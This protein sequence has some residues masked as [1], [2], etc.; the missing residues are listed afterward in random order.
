MVRRRA[1]FGEQWPR[2]RLEP[3]SS[4]PQYDQARWC[5]AR[6]HCALARLASLVLCLVMRF[7]LPETW[8]QATNTVVRPITLED[9]FQMALA[10]NLDVQIERCAPELAR[11]RLR[12]SYGAYDP[13][14]SVRFERQV[15]SFP[16][17]VDPPRRGLDLAYDL[18]ADVLRPSLFGRLPT[19]LTFGLA[20]SAEYLSAATVFPPPTRFIQR[21]N[22]YA[23]MVEL[24]LSQPLL[25]DF[26]TDATRLRIMVNR[27]NLRVA[28]LALRYRIMRTVTQVEIAYHELIAARA[29]V[30]VAEQALA[31][32]QQL[33]DENRR[34]VQA[35]ALPP[36]EA[37]QAQA[38][39]ATAAARLLAAQQAFAAQ[40]IALKLLISDDLRA[41]PEV[42][43]AP[44]EAAPAPPM[45][46]QR[47]QSWEKAMTLRPDLVQARLEVEK[48]DQ[49]LRY[50]RNQLFPNLDVVGVF[51][52]RAV[53]NDLG[54]V[55][56]GIAEVRHP[57]YTI[58]MVLRLPLGNRAAR[59]AY[60]S[61]QAAKEQALARLKRLE[62][63]I[64]AQIDVAGQQ[65]Q[66]AFD[67]HRAAQRGEAAA[68]LALQAE[69]RKLRAGQ[70]T[71]FEMLRFQRNLTDARSVGVRAMADYHRAL[72]EL[73]LSEGA[74]LER[75]HLGVDFK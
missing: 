5:G 28:E 52:A 12:S 46:Y 10:H 2:R 26:W 63:Q 74:T 42:V 8:A 16:E 35:G 11:Y 27:K 69:E 71:F 50:R 64:L 32:A 72:A 45:V 75:H 4:N 55:A 24:T 21:T 7:W 73:A 58:G 61:A 51:G 39:A 30:R 68:Q 59:H 38:Q 22:Q 66:T 49:E 15:A 47:N 44:A 56:G 19:G 62:E 25:K 9:C 14:F 20:A 65:L 17:I 1:R 13:V 40:Q 53:Q 31:L 48:L 18:T 3:M 70:S 67:R 34:R 36:L 41:W 37:Q 57:N 23:A 54:D 33:E 60:R 29:S 43:L 6:R